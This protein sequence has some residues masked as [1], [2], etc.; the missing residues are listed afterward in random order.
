MKSQVCNIQCKFHEQMP[1]FSDWWILSN[2]KIIPPRKQNTRNNLDVSLTNPLSNFQLVIFFPSLIKSLK[3]F[4]IQQLY[5]TNSFS[6]YDNQSSHV[7]PPAYLHRTIVAI[8]RKCP[9][10]NSKL[11]VK[12]PF[13][14]D[15]RAD[16]V[17]FFYYKL[18]FGIRKNT[19]SSQLK[20]PI[21][22]GWTECRSGMSQQVMLSMF[23]STTRLDLLQ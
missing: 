19:K 5:F 18:A 22:W 10:F 20:K 16:S 14:Q 9:G 17:T 21:I 23:S 8:S 12:Q 13:W 7:S 11:N 3:K 6:F 15:K 1:A 4:F 2:G